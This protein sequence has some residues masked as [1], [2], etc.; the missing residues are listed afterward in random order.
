MTRLEHFFY[1]LFWVGFLSW[2]L[3]SGQVRMLRFSSPARRD[4]QPI[5]YWVA[6]AL[7]GALFVAFVRYGRTWVNR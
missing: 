2:E 1:V 6:L 7:Q 5:T 3:Y 4:E